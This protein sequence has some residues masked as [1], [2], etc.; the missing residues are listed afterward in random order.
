MTSIATN[1]RLACSAKDEGQKV[2]LN[3]VM[4]DLCQVSKRRGACPPGWFID[5]FIDEGDTIAVNNGYG[6]VL[7][8]KAT[9]TTFAHECGHLFGMRDVYIKGEGDNPLIVNTYEMASNEYLLDDWN[10][11]CWGKGMSGARYYR[12]QTSMQ[13]IINRMLMNGVDVGEERDITSGDVYGVWYYIGENG[14]EVWNK[15]FVPVGWDFETKDE[16]FNFYHN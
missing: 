3:N 13:S 5:S 8:Q 6:M 1:F 16:S 15:S 9:K 7:T 11:G 14:E 4:S 2:I 12:Y 10:G